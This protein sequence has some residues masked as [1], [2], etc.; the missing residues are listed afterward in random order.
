ME[1]NEYGSRNQITELYSS[2]KSDH[3]TFKDV[4]NRNRCNLQKIKEHFK[5]YY[6]VSNIDRDPVELVKAPSFIQTLQEISSMHIKTGPPDLEE[7]ISVIK[8]FKKAKA[9]SDIP[10][11]FI[12]LRLQF[13]GT[14]RFTLVCASV[15]LCVSHRLSWKPFDG[16]F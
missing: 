12:G 4:K 3:S 6:E 11:A 1:I 16:I 2:F 7:L 9:A 10:I 13:E 8:K 14:Y 15:R 5:K